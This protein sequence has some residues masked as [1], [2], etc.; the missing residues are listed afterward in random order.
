MMTF[1]K[2]QAASIFGSI[3]DFL[4]TL[5][6]VDIFHYWYLIANLAG[7]ICGAIVQFLISRD[8]AFG[9]AK[10][11]ILQRALK[12]ILVWLGNLLLSAGT[13]YCITRFLGLNYLL[14]KLISSAMLGISY[15]YLTLKKFVF[16]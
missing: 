2:V 9:Q 10:D 14:S 11:K 1:L 12:F 13:V 15:Q 16:N 6:L 5:I 3:A 4:I 7:N 8:W